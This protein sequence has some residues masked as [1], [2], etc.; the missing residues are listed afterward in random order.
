[1][2]IINIYYIKSK[3]LRSSDSC[4][5]IKGMWW[6]MLWVAKQISQT[7]QWS[8]GMTTRRPTRSS[9]Y[10][11][12][13]LLKEIPFQC[14]LFSPDT[15]VILLLIHH[16]PELQ[17][18]T[19]FWTGW[20]DQLLLSTSGNAAKQLDRYE[21]ECYLVQWKNQ[22]VLVEVTLLWRRICSNCNSRIGWG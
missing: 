22:I 20:R 15:D 12:M 21:W 17:P 2:V 8:E 1:M 13:M 4:Y 5:L 10:I 6:Q 7:F 18:C 3:R 9:F 19:L 11:G 14:V 16:F